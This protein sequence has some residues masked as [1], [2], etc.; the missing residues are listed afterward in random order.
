MSQKKPAPKIKGQSK[1][2]KEE[3]PEAEW[4]FEIKPLNEAEVCYPEKRVSFLDIGIP[5]KSLVHT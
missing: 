4:K 5:K 2:H 3:G 1:Q